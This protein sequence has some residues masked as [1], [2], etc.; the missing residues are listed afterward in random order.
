MTN[1]CSEFDVVLASHLPTLR[2]RARASTRNDADAADLV[3]DTIERALRALPTL[4]RDSNI[5]AWLMTIM[6]RR[7]IDLSR[8]GQLRR[9]SLPDDLVAVPSPP[10][11]SPVPW[12]NIGATELRQA[13]S[14]LPALL[15][16]TLELRLL[17]RLPC[18]DIAQRLS[19]PLCTV[20]TRLLRARLRLRPLLQPQAAHPVAAASVELEAAGI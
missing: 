14:R 15:R 17:E 11:Y 1:Q 10:A 9:R 7:A 5:V 19:I 3:Q 12:E 2:R 20:H 4:R 16:T 13:I 8:Q 6:R 18:R